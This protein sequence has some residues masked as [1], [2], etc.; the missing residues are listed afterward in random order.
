MKTPIALLPL[1][2]AI[3]SGQASTLL[4]LDTFDRANNANI[5]GSVAGVSGTIGSTFTADTVYTQP[6]VDPANESSG[7]D[8]VA[9]NGGGAQISGNRL[10]L[11]VGSGTSNAYINHNFTDAAITSAGGMSITLDVPDYGGTDRQ[12]GGGFA[13]G[14]SQIEADSARDAF[15]V[16][17]PSMLGAYAGPDPWG[18]TGNPVSTNIVSDFWIGVRGNQSLAW[19]SNTGNVLGLGQNALAQKTG[20]IRVDFFFSDFN[21]GSTVNYEVFFDGGSVGTGNFQWSETNQNYIGLDGRSG[22]QVSYD[23]FSISTVPEPSIALLGGLGMLGL[24][25][26]RR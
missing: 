8:G 6:F 17:D 15:N 11:A 26:R 22:A 9:S 3:G 23:N 25:R 10:Q 7:P 13:I 2:A 21:A 19:G 24:I 12:H 16:G 20:T 5:D 18:V 1:L 4:F 14:M